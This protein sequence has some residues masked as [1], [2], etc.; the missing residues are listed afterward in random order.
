[1]D[2]PD[3]LTRL[4][5]YSESLTRKAEKA[6]L[7][8][9]NIHSRVCELLEEAVSVSRDENMPELEKHRNLKRIVHRIENE[10]S[11]FG[12]EA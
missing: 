10:T 2:I 12:E 3:D 4:F 9:K 7:R 5:I 8:A 6:C 1:M 11:Y